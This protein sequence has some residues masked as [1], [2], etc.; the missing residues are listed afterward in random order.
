MTWGIVRGIVRGNARHATGN[1]RI[2]HTLFA[3]PTPE[4]YCLCSLI[5]IDCPLEGNVRLISS[6]R[7]RAEW[8]N[9][10]SHQGRSTV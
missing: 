10:Y 5:S 9:S 3:H 8:R 1:V 4:Q 7:V 2:E 6:V